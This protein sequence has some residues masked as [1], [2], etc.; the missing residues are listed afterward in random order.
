MVGLVRSTTRSSASAADALPGRFRPFFGRVED[1]F[2]LHTALAVHEVTAVFHLV[3]PTAHESA[4][5]EDRGTAAVR[6]ALALYDRRVPLVVARPSSDL[7]LALPDVAPSAASPFGVVRFDELFGEGDCKV[8]RL[9]PRTLGNVYGFGG[10]GVPAAV[11]PEGRP[12]DF[13]YVRDAA[14]A[15]L[16]VAEALSG[17]R[18]SLDLTFRS[19]WKLSENTFVQALLDVSTGVEPR[20]VGVETPVNPLGW[21]PRTDLATALR[22]TVAWYRRWF[23]RH[24]SGVQSPPDRKAA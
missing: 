13:V 9:V 1:A 19:G 11:A 14:R 21:A 7:R 15:C 4:L 5:K 23:T 2:R 22:E 17:T 6:R 24:P 16:L 8:D 18:E 10:P 12:R 3:A 20:A